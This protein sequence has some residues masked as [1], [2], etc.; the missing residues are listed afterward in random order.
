MKDK[1][2]L[3]G[4]RHNAERGKT[5]G[6]KTEREQ[7]YI[8][9]VGKL[10]SGF[11]STPQRARLVAYRDAMRDVA[12]KYP[13][14]HEAQIFY[15]LAVAASEDPAD[16]TYAGRLEAGASLEEM[17]EEVRGHPRVAP[18]SIPTDH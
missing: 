17:V 1:S 6:A 11:E 16:K 2:Q 7:A 13:E 8:A 14:D 12:A 5:V 3:Q 15:A 18:Y 10:Y 4:G 9:A